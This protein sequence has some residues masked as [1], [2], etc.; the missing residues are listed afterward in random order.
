VVVELIFILLFDLNTV[1]KA[2]KAGLKG[3]LKMA[4]QGAKNTTKALFGAGRKTL[5]NSGRN[6][7]KVGR[8]LVNI[9]AGGTKLT[10]SVLKNGFSRGV[11]TVQDLIGRIKSNLSFKK[12]RIRRQGRWFKLEGKLNPWVWLASGEIREVDSVKGT[13]D[14]VR[15]VGE[16]GSFAAKGGDEVIEG[17]LIGGT[18]EASNLVRSLQTDQV[19]KNNFDDLIEEI[20]SSNAGDLI[21]NLDSIANR[22]QTLNNQITNLIKSTNPKKVDVLESISNSLAKGNIPEEDIIGSLSDIIKAG[23]EPDLIAK[24][25]QEVL[26]ELSNASRVADD[27]T[28]VVRVNAVKNTPY[29]LGDGI[30]VK[31]NPMDEIDALFKQGDDIVAHEVKDTMNALMDKI[32]DG[33]QIKKMVDWRTAGPNRIVEFVVESEDSW[34]KLFSLA[35][36]K[37]I[38][39]IIGE[40][41]IPLNIGGRHFSPDDL[42]VLNKKMND[43][44]NL[45]GLHPKDFFALPEL[46]NLETALTA[47]GFK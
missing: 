43:Y 4:A 35:K 31:I 22:S 14:V 21:R 20:G 5:V 40:R 11:K 7:L 15:N 26:S 28:G 16:T 30:I 10:V 27:I 13:D 23:G 45:K 33:K 6:T 1:L 9:G 12:F 42:L 39:T 19:L 38:A 41:K 37:T 32:R 2:A 34:T 46:E 36:G 17:V 44:F 3:S 18:D 24:R 47:I 8:G 25:T 29:D